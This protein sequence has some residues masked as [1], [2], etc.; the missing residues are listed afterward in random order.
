ML[1]SNHIIPLFTHEQPSSSRCSACP[2]VTSS[3]QI[4]SYDANSFDYD[5]SYQLGLQLTNSYVDVRTEFT[6]TIYPEP[7]PDI[8]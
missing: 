6:L 8:T 1:E 5:C 4:I 3:E 2:T 7:E